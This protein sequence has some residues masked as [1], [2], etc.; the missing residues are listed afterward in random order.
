MHLPKSDISLSRGFRHIYW[1]FGFLPQGKLTG[2]LGDTGPQLL[3]HAVVVTLPLWQ[4]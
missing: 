3:A 1:G 4:S 2:G